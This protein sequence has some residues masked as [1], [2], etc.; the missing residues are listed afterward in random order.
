MGNEIRLVEWVGAGAP[1]GH[2]H[3]ET[4]GLEDAGEG[5]D[6]DGVERALLGEDLGDER[7]SRASQEDQTAHVAQGAGGV[8]EGTDTVRLDTGA[9]EGGTPC[10]GGGS[11][12][13]ALE[14]LLLG[15]G[16]LGL[17]VG[18]TED[19]AEDGEGD[20]V[21][22]DRAEGDGGRLN[23]REVVQSGHFDGDGGCGLDVEYG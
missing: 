6:G 4:D 23:R 18:V 3:G 1:P 10:G 22:V 14:E 19:G 15:V 9:D 2:E 20:G 11:S 21:V 8:Q 5:T 16:G 12:L 17:A 13:L 7:W